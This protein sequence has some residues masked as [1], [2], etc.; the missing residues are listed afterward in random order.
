MKGHCARSCPSWRHGRSSCSTSSATSSIDFGELYAVS[1]AIESIARALEP[2]AAWIVNADDPLVASLAAD[3]PGRRVTFGLDLERSTDEITRAADSIRCPRCRADLVYDRVYL[4]HLGAYRCPGCGFARP[5]LDV[6]VTALEVSGL[7]ETN[8]TVRLP[9]TELVLRIPQPGVHVAYDVAAALA[10][11]VG[12]G[13]LPVHAAT[14]LAA[15][16]PAFGRLEQAQAGDRRIALGFVKNP[17]SYNTTLHALAGAAEPRQLLIAA[18]N[19]P[20]DGE[21]FAWLWDVDFGP[22]AGLVE[23]VTISGTRAD[24]LANR[25]KYAGV[26]PRS[27]TVV[28]DR[29]RA[30][31]AALAGTPPGGQLTILA[32]YTPMLELRALMQE[33]GWVG[34]LR[35][36]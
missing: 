34:S 5:E 32:G 21:D 33:R 16:K 10:A 35:E 2:E 7:A 9:T 3:R 31:E 8:L 20:V 27:M 29:R 36:A 1:G 11:M 22:A 13:I 15:V 25:L 6:A 12:L 24:E 23:R 30:F 4:S 14:A 28:A 17:T 19:T 26:D 18:S